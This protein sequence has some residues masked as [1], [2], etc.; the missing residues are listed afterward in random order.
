RTNITLYG[1]TARVP[2]YATLGVR[3]AL[4]T[5]WVVTGSMNMLRELRCA[6]ELNTLRYN[7]YFTDEQLWLMA[8][9][10]S[11]ASM[12]IDNVL[13]VIQVGGI[14]DLAMFDGATHADHRAILDA[15]PA[16]VVMVMRGGKVLYGDD[17]VVSALAP[18]DGCD[19]INVCGTAKRACVSREYGQSYS[20]L[21]ASVSGM[22]PLFF[23]DEP[24]NEPSCVPSRDAMDPYPDPER[25]GST[26]YSG[27]ITA[28]DMDGDGI[29]DDVDNCLLSFNP[30][31][32]VDQGVQADFDG[33]GL[34]DECDPCPMDPGKLTCDALD[35]NDRDGDGIPNDQD[36]CP[37]IPNP[38]QSN[39][40]GDAY[41]D[42]CD[43]CPDAK[44]G[45][46]AGCPA[47]IYDIQMGTIPV[48]SPV[49][50]GPSVVTAIGQSGFFMQVPP[51]S[52]GY[53]GAARSGLYVYTGAGPTVAR[54]D[55]VSV[56]LAYVNEYRGQKQLGS[57]VFTANGTAAVPAPVAVGATDVAPGGAMA[58]ALE[59]VL[60]EISNAAVTALDE[61]YPA[62]FTVMGGAVV[63]DFL[64][65]VDPT[66]S[67]G[68][69][70]ASIAGV[71]VLRGG[72][73]KIMPRDG[74][75]VAAGMPG[76]S[77]FGPSPTYIRAGGGAGPTIP[78]ALMVTLSRAPATSTTVTV[79]ASGAGLIVSNV[80]VPAGMKSAVVPIQGVTPSA[81]PITVS[82]TLGSHTEQVS[83]RVIGASE[84]PKVAAITP[85]NATVPAGG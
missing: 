81:T 17:S 19:A 55:L 6:D 7:S 42:E 8:T 74:A 54:G 40:D 69:T 61:K 45:E 76:L 71:L 39:K 3:I 26:R 31:R 5:D 84:S 75:D 13:G 72:G 34:G 18:S 53:T 56:S 62:Q 68:E 83:V 47:S 64:Y 20:E 43:F 24:E 63:S 58:V 27:E 33:D 37:V 78:T 73:V 35:P 77:E 66:P 51:G 67:V 4:G 49:T 70:F 82:A 38:A 14:A 52:D 1:D 48:G 11:A 30:V 44:N 65:A 41:G 12:A 28:N 59:S 16:S 36:N 80:T 50:V 85:A 22:Y 15:T 79:S 9:R 60:V 46:G 32:P 25:N 2:V 21:E 57:A 10:D 23:C 29:P